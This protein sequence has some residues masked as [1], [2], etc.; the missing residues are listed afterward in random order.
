MKKPFNTSK[1]HHF[2]LLPEVLYKQE[3]SGPN[4]GKMVPGI[5]SVS[6]RDYT[7]R[8]GA[9]NRGTGV[10]VQYVVSKDDRGRD[11]GKF[12][13]LSQSHNAFM[14][15]ETDSDLYG[16]K[17]FDF[18]ANH[19]WCEGSP[20]GK[21]FENEN[22]DKVQ[23]D[24]KFRLM[25]SEA[26]AEVALAATLNRSKAQLSASEI[27]EQTLS[28]VAAIGIGAHGKPDKMMRHKVVEWAGKRPNDYFTVLE[29]GDRR[30][31]AIVRKGVADGVL[32]I[33]DPLIYWNSTLLGADEDATI[34]YLLS[35]PDMLSALEEKVDLKSR[36][37]EPPKKKK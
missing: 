9:L 16:T 20:N 21:Y 3:I 33:K 15:N 27:D 35:N 36:P 24:V 14:V 37:S 30:L 22:G 32:T 1:Y 12:F 25:N 19:P 18:I 11:K 7:D 6:F 23:I 17:M 31:R 34:S 4:A 2:V 26:D 5:G 8:T 13:T 28:E 10:A 29:S